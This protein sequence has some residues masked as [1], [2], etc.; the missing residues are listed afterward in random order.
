MADRNWQQA[1]A[2][3]TARAEGRV[4]QGSP[5]QLER[6][7]RAVVNLIEQARD[8]RHR[9]PG[10]Q[11]PADGVLALRILSK[12]VGRAGGHRESG[13][14]VSLADAAR[15]W[16]RPSSWRYGCK[17]TRGLAASF[18]VAFYGDTFG[19]AVTLAAL[20]RAIG[21]VTRGELEEL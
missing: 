6:A 5:T 9:G 21:I 2:V 10:P 14:G 18:C 11:H 4:I 12:T 13:P 15:R 16:P 19:H 20:R 7:L 1:L 17:E 3:K 8:F